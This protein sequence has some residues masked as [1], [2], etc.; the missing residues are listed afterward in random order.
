[1]RLDG[2]VL[3]IGDT[4][5]PIDVPVTAAIRAASI[6]F[7][8]DRHHLVAERRTAAWVHGAIAVLPRPHR[9]CS[10]VHGEPRTR[11]HAA[12]REVRFL[13]DEIQEFG[14]LRVT[15]PLRTAWDLAR[16]EGDDTSDAV[17]DALLQLARVTAA[18]AADLLAAREPRL[19]HQR[20]AQAR[21]AGASAVRRRVSRR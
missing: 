9:F 7:G 1:M 11:A 20:I 14:G 5:I 17:F 10:D 18:E 15:T 3:R 8:A 6:R 13:R 16:L 21:L 4:A 2:D 12:V 19:P